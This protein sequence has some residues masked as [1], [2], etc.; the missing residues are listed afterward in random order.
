MRISFY[1]GV[2]KKKPDFVR[3]SVPERGAADRAAASAARTLHTF[4][5]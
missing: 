3:F 1:T 5:V 2:V 4:M